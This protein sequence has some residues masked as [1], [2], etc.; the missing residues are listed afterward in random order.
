MDVQAFAHVGKLPIAAIRFNQPSI[1]AYYLRSDWD[2]SG[3]H[4]A[5]DVFLPKN[6]HHLC[7]SYNRQSKTIKAVLVGKKISIKSIEIKVTFFSFRM[8]RFTQMALI[9]LIRVVLIRQN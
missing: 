5:D 8:E 1:S 2:L 3:A 9:S 7:V 6:W 4:G